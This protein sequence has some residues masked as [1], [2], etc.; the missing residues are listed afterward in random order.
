MN[1]RQEIVE[2]KYYKPRKAYARFRKIVAQY[3]RENRD[4]LDESMIDR[5]D[6]RGPTW[7]MK[8]MTEDFEQYM[9]GFMIP[10]EEVMP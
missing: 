7:T 6:G 5:N 1:K 3:L 10:E 9:L 4:D 2:H 8:E